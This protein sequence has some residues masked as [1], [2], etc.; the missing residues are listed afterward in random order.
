M[1]D[2]KK[3]SK[4][5]LRDR[6]GKSTP[7]GV[8]GVTPMPTPAPSG[9]GMAVPPVSEPGV[10]GPGARPPSVA[11]AAM[12]PPPGLS[13]GIPLP[14]FAQPRQAPRAEPKPTAAQQT[15]KVE[16]GEE[17]EQERKKWK[18]RLA[19]TGLAGAVVGAVI[20]FIAGSSKADG[21]RLRAAARGAGLLEKDVK[22]A[23]EKL[24]DLDTKLG[25]AAD[26]LKAKTYPDDLAQSLA[27]LKIPFEASNLERKGL[28]PQQSILRMAISF[29]MKVET[30]D[31][32]RE[33]LRNI[34]TIAKD[35]ITKAW[36]EETAPVA[37]YSVI[38]R[39]EGGKAAADLVP[40]KEPFPWK[41]DW[42]AN[43]KV[44]KLEG[45]RPADK[46]ATRWV[47]GDIMGSDTIAIPVDPKTMAAFT[48]EA[49]IG[50]L[51]KAIYDMRLELAGDKNDPNGTG[52]LVKIGDDLANELRKASL[53]Q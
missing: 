2:D 45:G 28:G 12:A 41:G 49:L 40:N 23:V 18:Q 52:G 19:L 43:Y 13:S 44:V 27:S 21:D 34:V 14:P 47:K 32:N 46:S 6:L 42:A 48:S 17:I 33:S 11:P 38:F 15:I 37:N 39:S 16:V 8:A 36:K 7:A 1:A 24:K 9:G 5:N 25:E 53:N 22:V 51:A 50:K 4:I 26:K 29:T 31:K 35:P 30:I 20:A 10:A 3:K